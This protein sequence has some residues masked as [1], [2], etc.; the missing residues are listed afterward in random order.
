MDFEY[1]H[2][3]CTN[4]ELEICKSSKEKWIPQDGI[5]TETITTLTE[6]NEFK[7]PKDIFMLKWI[8]F[9]SLELFLQIYKNNSD[10]EKN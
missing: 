10:K 1:I 2:I 3:T 6:K 5:T 8:K 9:T 7:S 4:T